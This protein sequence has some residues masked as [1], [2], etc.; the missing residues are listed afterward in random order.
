[1][2][3]WVFL[4]CLA[5]LATAHVLRTAKPEKR[6]LSDRSPSPADAHPPELTLRSPE[7][8]EHGGERSETKAWSE[9]TLPNGA[10]IVTVHSTGETLRIEEGAAV[11]EE[12]ARE[13]GFPGY[14]G[15]ARGGRAAHELDYSP[16]EKR[17]VFETYFDGVALATCQYTQTSSRPIVV[18]AKLDDDARSLS[19]YT[20]CTWETRTPASPC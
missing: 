7:N 5:W 4:F 3:R 8:S 9:S 14:D 2:T 12:E 19:V 6:P 13:L 20:P 16:V 18:K 11:T 1:M 17:E 15:P 10:R